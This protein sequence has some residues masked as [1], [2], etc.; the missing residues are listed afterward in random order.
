MTTKHSAPT[1][2]DVMIAIARLSRDNRRPSSA[3]PPWASAIDARAS[4][5]ST[6]GAATTI[7]R[8]RIS[9]VLL[10]ASD[11][12]HESHDRP[13]RQPAADGLADPVAG[14]GQRRSEQQ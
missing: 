12:L 10:L 7:C 14:G 6:L 3:P 4:V 9:A 11:L 5:A 8:V 2:S 13:D 1:T